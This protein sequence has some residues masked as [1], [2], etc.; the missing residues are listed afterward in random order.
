MG[1]SDIIIDWS[2]ITW[3]KGN[4]ETERDMYLIREI[5]NICFDKRLKDTFIAYAI[6]IRLLKLNAFACVGIYIINL[7]MWIVLVLLLIYY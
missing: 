1:Q 6:I 2:S 7:S 3:F 4:I 5:S